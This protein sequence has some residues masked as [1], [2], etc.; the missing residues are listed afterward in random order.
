[1][2][3]LTYKDSSVPH[4]NAKGELWE[5]YSDRNYNEVISKLAS[6]EDAEEQ[7]RL[8]ILPCKIGAK[9][10]DRDADYVFTVEKAETCTVYGKPAIIFRCGNPGKSDYMAFYD[11]EIG[12]NI[13]ILPEES[14]DG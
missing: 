7:G 4:I 3:R 12:K 1:M 5:A 14:T 10:K 6:Y 13:E 2:E 9:V 8:I 11:F